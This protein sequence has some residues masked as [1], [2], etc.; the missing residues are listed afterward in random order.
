MGNARTKVITVSSVVGSAAYQRGVRDYEKGHGFPSER[1]PARPT[2]KDVWHYERGR[3]AAAACRGKGIAVLPSRSGRKVSS[4][5][6]R[7]LGDL[8]IDGDVR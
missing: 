5:A 7:Q 3:L 1:D 8:F 4:R 6:C 2:G